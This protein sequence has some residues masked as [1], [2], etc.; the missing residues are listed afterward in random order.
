MV[1][2]NAGR[3]RRQSGEEGRGRGKKLGGEEGVRERKKAERGRRRM[4]GGRG[5]GSGGAGATCD[6]YSHGGGNTPQA[7]ALADPDKHGQTQGFKKLQSCNRTIEQNVYE[8]AQN[9]D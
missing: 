7:T 8:S 9:L 6:I 2:K 1:I 5:K 3:A 4:L